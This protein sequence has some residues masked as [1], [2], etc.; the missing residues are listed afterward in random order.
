VYTPQ[1]Q[2]P[3]T[4]LSENTVRH[5]GLGWLFPLILGWALIWTPLSVSA[6]DWVYVVQPGDNV[7]FLSA[8]LLK[9]VNHYQKL[10][11]YNNITQP[12]PLQ[13]GT[14]LRVPLAWLKQEPAKVKVVHSRG[15]TEVFRHSKR[16]AKSLRKGDVLGLGDRIHTGP[17][18]NVTLKFADGSTLVIQEQSEVVLDTLAVSANG[19]MVETRVRLNQGR[20]EVE[21]PTQRKPPP[22]FEII[23]PQSVTSVRGTRFR[24]ETDSERNITLSEVMDGRVEVIAGGVTRVV[25]AGYGIVAQ[26]GKPLRQPRPLLSRPN[27]S[28]LTARI[29][30]LPVAFVWPPVKDAKTY[31][32]QIA[33]DDSFTAL[34][35]D[36]VL[37]TSNYT[38]TA[39]SDG[40]YTLRIRA[41]DEFGLEGLSSDFGF[42]LDTRPDAA[43]T[44]GPEDG[45]SSTETRPEFR[46][47]PVKGARGYHLQL[48]RDW[49]FTEII[50][51]VYVDAA[52]YYKMTSGQQGLPPNSYYWRV[53]SLDKSGNESSFSNPKVTVVRSPPAVDRPTLSQ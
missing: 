33:P 22:S 26:A 23:T 8:T 45:E 37:T 42:T 25:T 4:V 49:A 9:D 38:L 50:L 21:V 34:L 41:M 40:Q 53:A 30:R 10:L 44:I 14:Q 12:K 31:R 18:S 52:D 19:I 28:G 2:T 51:D 27:L 39:L 6:E 13:P 35:I 3:H 48:A 24:V 5:L 20:G 7:W 47:K 1:N 16:R 46:W 11:Q 29:E 43:V 32:I 15:R 36:T 17:D